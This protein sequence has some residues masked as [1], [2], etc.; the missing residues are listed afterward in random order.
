M[1]PRA[2]SV[3]GVVRRA[4][5]FGARDEHLAVGRVF[6]PDIERAGFAGAVVELAQLGAL[7]SASC[8]SL[9]AAWRVSWPPT[10]GTKAR[11]ATNKAF[12]N[13]LGEWNIDS[14]ET[15]GPSGRDGAFG[16]RVSRVPFRVIAVIAPTRRC[17]RA[18]CR[19]L[20]G[21]AV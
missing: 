8:E 1:T 15:L 14:A 12:F 6:E 2:A 5:R 20:P 4:H 7:S 18:P 10:P 19:C 17:W 21:R 9:G 11:A 16:P 13:P 3:V